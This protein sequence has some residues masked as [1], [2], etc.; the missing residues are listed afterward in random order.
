MALNTNNELINGTSGI[1][2]DGTA[3]RGGYFVV[4]RLEITTTGAEGLIPDYACVEGALCFCKDNNTFYKCTIG[5]DGPEWEEAE[6]NEAAHADDATRADTIKIDSNYYKISYS[7][8]T[9]AFTLP[10]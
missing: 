1:V 6:F 2:V 4:E 7:S 3:V 9:L 8:G 10:E 5:A